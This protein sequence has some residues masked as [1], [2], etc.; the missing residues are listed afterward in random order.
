MYAPDISSMI[1]TNKSPLWDVL[2]RMHEDIRAMSRRYPVAFSPTTRDELDTFYSEWEQ[3]IDSIDYDSLDTNGRVDYHLLTRRISAGRL[4]CSRDRTLYQELSPWLTFA[5][6]IIRLVEARIGFERLPP[7]EIGCMLNDI[8][9]AIGECKAKLAD[10]KAEDLDAANLKG[11]LGQL[12]NHLK[13]WYKEAYGY[14][15]E[16]S[17]WIEKPHA[18]VKESLDAYLKAVTE[19]IMGDKEGADDP[20]V[21]ASPMGRDAILTLLANE[22]ICYEPEELFDIAEKELSICEQEMA[23]VAEEMGYAGDRAGALEHI[24]GMHRDPGD[25]PYVAKELADEAI[26]FLESNDLVTL[27]EHAKKIWRQMMIAPD[28]QKGSYTFLWGGETIGTSYSHK[29]LTHEQ[30]LTSMR[31]NCIPFLKATVHHEL[32]PGHHLMMYMNDRFSTHRRGYGTPFLGEGWP[33]YWELLLYR[34]GFATDPET[35]YG[36]LFWRMHR[37]AR[38]MVVLGFHIGKLSIQDCL[39]LAIKRVG[40]DEHAGTSQVRW[41]IAGDLALYGAAYMLGGL[42]LMG[43][44]AELVDSGK[45]TDKEFHDGVLKVNLMPIYLVRS[46]LTGHELA[47]QEKSDWQFYDRVVESRDAPIQ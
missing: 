21:V 6:D 7:R 10:V 38:I 12:K 23:A 30:K 39:D 11:F 24:K 45:M 47:K 46:I 4:Q 34:M 19:D 33:L 44:R 42:Q 18:Q 22:Y 16:L 9:I 14:D 20:P 26:A 2:I 13:S 17:W 5:P 27:P 3:E 37:C 41:L 32:I 31:S 36:F 35:R 25:Q 28:L 1:S 15:P 29:I 8:A 43:L 40:H